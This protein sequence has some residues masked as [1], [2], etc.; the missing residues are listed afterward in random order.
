MGA[1]QAGVLLLSP[2]TMIC[3]GCLELSGVTMGRCS[4]LLFYG[5]ASTARCRAASFT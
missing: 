5:A 2:T 1:C 4:S 3:F